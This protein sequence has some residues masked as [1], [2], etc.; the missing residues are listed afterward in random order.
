MLKEQREKKDKENKDKM[1]KSSSKKIWDNSCQPLQTLMADMNI[2]WIVQRQNIW[3]NIL[4]NLMP[5][6]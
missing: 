3:P 4:K 5:S 2:L 1:Q 6:K